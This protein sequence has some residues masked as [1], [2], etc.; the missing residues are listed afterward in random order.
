MSVMKVLRLDGRVINIGDWDPQ[1]VEVDVN[2]IPEGVTLA[3]EPQED[4]GYALVWRDEAREIVHVGPW[5]QRL[6]LRPTSVPPEGAF[7]SLEDV[8]RGPDGGLYV[9]AD[10]RLG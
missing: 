8:V 1:S 10:P 6:E 3:E 2:P 9:A 7:W 4:G 5:E